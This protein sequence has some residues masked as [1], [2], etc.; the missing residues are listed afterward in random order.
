M[1]VDSGVA[2]MIGGEKN[3]FLVVYITKMGKRELKAKEI[4]IKRNSYLSTICHE[5][6]M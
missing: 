5:K 2:A 3:S 6:K 4:N 1:F